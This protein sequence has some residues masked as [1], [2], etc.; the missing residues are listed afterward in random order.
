MCQV[1]NIPCE[2]QKTSFFLS[3][4]Q[5]VYIFEESPKSIQDVNGAVYCHGEYCL[6][7]EKCESFG[8]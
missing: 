5:K 7:R 4:C 2:N 8:G 6:N 1:R 3:F